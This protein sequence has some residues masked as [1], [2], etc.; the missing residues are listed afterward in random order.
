MGNSRIAIRRASSRDAAMLAKLGARTFKDAFAS[1]TAEPDLMSYLAEAFTVKRL[2]SELADSR[3][4]FLIAMVTGRPV[5]YAKLYAGAVPDSISDK[6]AVELARLYS[7]Q[8]WLGRGVGAALM[9]TCLDL[10]RQQGYSTIW[11]SS[12]KRNDRAN[13]FYQKWCFQVVGFKTFVM[14]ADIQEDFILARS[15]RQ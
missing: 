6:S 3:S 12:W 2:S 8:E 15:L 7:C 5:G 13:A 14:G 4:T 9:E 10:A 1:L 11:L